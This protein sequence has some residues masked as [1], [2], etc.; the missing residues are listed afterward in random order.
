MRR[1]VWAEDRYRVEI[2]EKNLGFFGAEDRGYVLDGYGSDFCFFPYE[3]CVVRSY[4]LWP[5]DD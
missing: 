5:G 3:S 2:Q 1:I 4:P